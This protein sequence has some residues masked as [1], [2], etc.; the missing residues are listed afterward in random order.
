MLPDFTSVFLAILQTRHKC[1]SGAETK[2]PQK[3]HDMRFIVNSQQDY[4]KTKEDLTA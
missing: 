1:S 3:T 4:N 2:V